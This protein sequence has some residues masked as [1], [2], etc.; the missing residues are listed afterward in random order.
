MLPL[1]PSFRDSSVSSSDS[2]FPSSTADKISVNGYGRFLE[3]FSNTVTNA[4]FSNEAVPLLYI[5]LFNHHKLVSSIIVF[6][7]HCWP[8]GLFIQWMATCVGAG[9]G[10]VQIFWVQEL[11]KGPILKEYYQNKKWQK[12]LDKEL[13]FSCWCKFHTFYLTLVIYWPDLSWL[14]DTLQC[15]CMGPVPRVNLGLFR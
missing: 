7:R 15:R 4:K 1:L 13:L 14:R 5:F 11:W 9:Q 8:L 6:A 3:T 10:E 12:V 2:C